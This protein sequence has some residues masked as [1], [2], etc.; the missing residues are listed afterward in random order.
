MSHD[1]KPR[2]LVAPRLAP[3]WAG[4]IFSATRLLPS[5]FSFIYLLGQGLSIADVSNARLI[6]LIALLLLEVPSGVLADRFGPRW[7]LLVSAFVSASWLAIMTVV[8][9]FP[10]LVVAE[11]LNAVSLSLFS[12]SFE[13]LLRDTHRAK[14]PMANFGKAQALWIAA[15]SIVGA[16]FATV[17]SRQAAW[18][19]AAVIQATLFLWLWWD[20]RQHRAAP[21]STPASA[22]NAVASL[23]LCCQV[24]R[25]MPARLWVSFVASTLVFDISLQFWQ[26]MIVIQGAPAE[27]NLLLM[28]ISL[29]LMAAMSMG[30]ALEE[31]AVRHRAIAGAVLTTPLFLFVMESA[32]GSIRLVFSAITICL[33]VAVSSALQSRATFLIVHAVRGDAEVTVFS[34]ISALSRVLSGILIVAVGALL[35][36]GLSVVVVMTGLLV[37]LVCSLLTA[38]TLDGD[39]S[40]AKAA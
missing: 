15:A 21:S 34:V 10:S 8:H 14:N 25:L 38:R 4:L 32:S 24:I 29:V 37:I 7:S 13:V 19:L 5:S 12:G 3:Y 18:A 20:M 30:N 16:I 33:L 26:P 39:T 27:S 2:P 9:D 6:Q 28:A 31:M 40:T 23:K 22:P 17:V 35:T 36:A 11:L 1:R